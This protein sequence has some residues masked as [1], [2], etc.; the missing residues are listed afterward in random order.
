[1]TNTGGRR[2]SAQERST[3]EWEAAYRSLVLAPR[4]L[5]EGVLPEMRSRG[6]GGS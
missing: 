6:W 2:P 1:M 4:A 3:A 5:I